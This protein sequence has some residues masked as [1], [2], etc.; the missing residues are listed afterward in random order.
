[1]RNR[2]MMSPLDRK[3]DE[4]ELLVTFEINRQNGDNRRYRRPYV[5]VWIE[6]K[7]GFPVR[8]LV[9]WVQANGRGP[10]W[11]PDLKR[12]YRD[13]QTRRLV[14][15]TDMVA[16]VARPTRPPGKYVLIWDGKDDQGKRLASGEYAVIIEAAREHGTYQTI[17]KPIRLEGRPFSDALKGNVEIQSA[18]VTY[19]K[20]TDKK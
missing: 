12:W 10:Q 19:R 14:D 11:I 4:F 20:K 3:E 6:D 16:T 18:S 13:D 2:T 8:T 7:D 15:E 5:A 17:R 1:M 9:L